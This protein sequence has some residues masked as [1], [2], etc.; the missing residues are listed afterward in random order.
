MQ[1]IDHY[2]KSIKTY[3]PRSQQEDILAELAENIRSQMEDRE[4]EIGRPLDEVEQ[5]EILRGI[6]N[7]LVVAGRYLNDHRSVAFGRQLIGPVLF[8]LYSRILLINLGV[9][10]VVCLVS[11]LVLGR[12]VWATPPAILLQLLFQFGIVTLIFTAAEAHLVRYPESWN[13]RS[14][15]SAAPEVKDPPQ[16]SRLQSFFELVLLWL[17]FGWLRALHR[18]IIPGTAGF[19]LMPVWHE[20]YSVVLALTAA[21]LLAAGLNLLFP[22]WMR[23]RLLSRAAIDGIWLAT[24]VYLIKAGS[25]IIIVDPAHPTSIRVARFTQILNDSIHVTL[26]LAL[27]I[28]A[29][30]FTYGLFRLTGRQIRIFPW[31]SGTKVL[32]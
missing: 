29:V 14:T 3:L 32:S 15:R 22:R 9:T 2:L 11:V 10:A 18:V 16:V 20:V 8:P 13:P 24:L 1:L 23:F 17:A 30:Q 4:A 5:E 6:G 19:R 25:W 12:S 27:L 21:A 31:P 26:I 28:S 7:P